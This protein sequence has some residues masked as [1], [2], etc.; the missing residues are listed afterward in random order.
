MLKKI[1]NMSVRAK[2]VT[3][4]TVLT[5]GYIIGI[6]VLSAF[7]FKLT[8]QLQGVAGMEA[9]IQARNKFFSFLFVALVIFAVL[10]ELLVFHVIRNLRKALA[11]VKTGIE[12]VASGDTNVEIEKISDDEIGEIADTT[13]A[14]VEN[15]CA[16]VSAAQ[17]VADGDLTTKIVP[18]SDKDALNIALKQL[19]TENN[20][21]MLSM[22]TA[23]D[24]VSDGSDQVSAASQAL[25]QGSTEQASAIQQIT[26]SIDDIAT[27]TRVSAED[28]NNA[29]NLVN[30]AKEGAELG[31]KRMDDMIQAMSDINESSENISK[32]I[33]VIDD[34][35]F[36]TNILA[37]NAAV[38]A[39]RAGTH[40]K[41]FA[42][43][44]DEVR[45][46]ARKSAEAASE[47]A[48]LI[49]NSIVKV[50]RGSQLAEETA[51]AL[52]DIM[53]AIDKISELV[54]N[55]AAS[56]NEQAT[57][58]SQIDQAIGQVS[59][60]VQNNSSTSEECA[61]AS[62]ELS[63]QALKLK[64]MIARFRLSENEPAAGTYSRPKRERTAPVE[65]KPVETVKPADPEPETP[66]AAIEQKPEQQEEIVISLDD[67]FGKY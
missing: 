19:V 66:V 12:K 26:A 4:C 30:G 57:A 40:G 55:I 1:D 15:I 24:Q 22:R 3:I 11:S 38:E 50:N 58:V 53:N 23:A 5:A 14:M 64:E 54:G 47:T 62:E 25:A 32:I 2:I 33:K 13:R 46:L 35:A 42:V 51:A 63:A 44:A 60:V 6:I 52:R 43:V 29:N 67:G 34:I 41:G 39:A 9:V 59:V 7:L 48:E 65:R 17:S 56:A 10:S 20:E 37:L 8:N 31:N 21:A 18:K 27:R 45:N 36:Q 28:A 61:A 16:Q 49:E